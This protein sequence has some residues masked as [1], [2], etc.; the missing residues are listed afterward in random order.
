[1]ILWYTSSEIRAEI[2]LEIGIEGDSE[3]LHELVEQAT[4]LIDTWTPTTEYQWSVVR[5]GRVV[6]WLVWQTAIGADQSWKAAF[7]DIE[8]IEPW[9]IK[10]ETLPHYGRPPT[11]IGAAD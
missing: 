5:A 11:A 10:L 6:D 8:M 1:M 9:A 7:H 3:M 4:T 2:L